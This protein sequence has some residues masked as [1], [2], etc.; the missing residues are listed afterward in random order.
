MSSNPPDREERGAP[1]RLSLDLRGSQGARPLLGVCSPP[2]LLEGDRETEEAPPVSAV[3][4]SSQCSV[5][6]DSATTWT[7][8]PGFPVLHYLL[9]FAQTHVH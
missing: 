4:S 9:E 6:S 3:P 5:M 1:L 8:T 7:A 2:V